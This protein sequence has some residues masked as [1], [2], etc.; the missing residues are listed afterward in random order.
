M[1]QWRERSPLANAARVRLCWTPCHIVWVGFV[2]GSRLA[3][4]GFLLVFR[5]FSPHKNQTLRDETSSSES[6]CFAIQCFTADL[7]YILKLGYNGPR[8]RVYINISKFQL[9][10]ERVPA[11]KLPKADLTS[12]LNGLISLFFEPIF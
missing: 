11:L 9:N 8:T 6:E 5:F 7:C 2:V 12:S 3:P 4:G 1:T 10:Q